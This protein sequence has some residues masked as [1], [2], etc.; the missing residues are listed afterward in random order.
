MKIRYLEGDIFSTKTQVLVNTVNC[1]GVMGKGLALEFRKRFPQ[2]YE[3]YKQ[4]CKE[5]RIT[6][7]S[8]HLYKQAPRYWILNFPTKNH[9]R[10]KSNLDYIERGLLEFR[11]KYAEWSISS[12]AFPKLGCQ[13]GGLDWDQVKPI[14][15]KHLSDLPGLR[16]EVFSHKTNSQRSI[17]RNK[18]RRLCQKDS[19]GPK[20]QSL[21]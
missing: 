7:G 11:K 1:Q 18:R 10:N 5:G 2:M 9:W 3:E 8:L 19:S 6:I 4:Q 21:A 16:V 14:M 12:I 13:L 17:R 15:E 20:Q